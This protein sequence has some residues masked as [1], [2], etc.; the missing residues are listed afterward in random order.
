MKKNLFLAL[1]VLLPVLQS[2]SDKNDDT[3][4]D[5]APYVLSMDIVD[6][7]GHNLLDPE[8]DGNIIGEK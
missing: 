2:C 3:I 7:E 1:L 8:V 6:S 5:Y 4:W